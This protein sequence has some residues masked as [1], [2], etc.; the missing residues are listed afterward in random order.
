MLMLRMSV[1]KDVRHVSRFHCRHGSRGPQA[2]FPRAPGE[3]SHREFPRCWQDD[4]TACF[5]SHFVFSRGEMRARVDPVAVRG[6][7]SIFV[8][9]DEHDRPGRQNRSSCTCARVRTFV[10]VWCTIFLR[11][12]CDTAWSITPVFPTTIVFPQV[13]CPPCWWRK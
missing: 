1:T 13:R 7:S 3:I 10:S 2:C 9:A 6:R 4:A 8:R 5:F 12:N 11:P